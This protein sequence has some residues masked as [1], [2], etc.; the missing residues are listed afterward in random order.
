M[1][2]DKHHQLRDRTKAFALRV[3]RISQA[4]PR[5][6]EA[7]VIAQQILR[8]ATGMGANYRAAGRSRSKAEFVAKIGVVI[9]EAD[10]TVFLVGDSRGEWSRAAA[11]ARKYPSRGQPIAGH[12]CRFAQ[13]R[14][15]LKGKRIASA[16][17]DDGDVGDDA[18]CRR[19]SR[20]CQ[21]GC[22]TTRFAA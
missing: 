14:E 12:L 2:V 19:S 18:R 22:P 6:R 20:P 17:P 5:T 11:E 10:E 3:I 1:S 7:N 9:E 16:G 4:L 15:G 8:S 13:N 21:T